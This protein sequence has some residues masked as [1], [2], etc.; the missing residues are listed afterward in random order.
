MLVLAIAAVPSGQN[1]PTGTTEHL[2]LVGDKLG[3]MPLS[4]HV[5]RA[6]VTKGA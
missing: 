6:F 5:R 3:H 4:G 1:D 2:V